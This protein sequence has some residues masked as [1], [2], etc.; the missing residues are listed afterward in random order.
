MSLFV[1]IL[2]PLSVIAILTRLFVKK[3][4]DVVHTVVFYILVIIGIAGGILTYISLERFGDYET[5]FA[6]PHTQ[7]VIESSEIIGDRAFR[8]LITYR[9]TVTD[10]TYT[11]QTSLA[12]PMFGGKRKKYDVAHVL[13]DQYPAGDTV[14]VY[15]NPQNPDESYLELHVPWEV[16][17]QLSF[18]V[19]LFLIGLVGLLFV[20]LKQTTA[21]E[22]SS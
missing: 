19:I 5:K 1:I 10:S 14:R 12:P 18:G 3:R 7:G 17:G 16:Y 13:T 9:F 20:R 22:S 6:Y 4:I 15:Y 2:F 11:A 21:S 8:P